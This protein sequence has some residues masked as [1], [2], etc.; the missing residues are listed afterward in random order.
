[1]SGLQQ[2]YGV[3]DHSLVFLSSYMFCIG[4]YASAIFLSQDARLRNF[5]R[6]SALEESKTLVNVGATQLKQQLERKVMSVTVPA[7]EL[8]TEKSGIKASLTEM[9]MKQYLSNVLKEIK[10][11]TRLRP[12]T[13][14]GKEDFG[15]LQ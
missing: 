9:E 13:I 4:L 7:R 10:V 15:K 6:K 14:R 5:I 3:A 11:S 2:T 12:N 1:M 8:L